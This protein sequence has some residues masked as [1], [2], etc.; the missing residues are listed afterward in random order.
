VEWL[1]SWIEEKKNNWEKA[2]GLLALYY[3]EK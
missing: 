3:D 2:L 1:E